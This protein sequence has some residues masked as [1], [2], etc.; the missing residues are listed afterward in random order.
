MAV[1][2]NPEL[3]QAEL[4][5]VAAKQSQAKVKTEAVQKAKKA[6]RSKVRGS[7]TPAAQAL[8]ANASIRDT[9]NASIRQLGKWKEL[10]YEQP[11]LIRDC[12][13]DFKKSV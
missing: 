12:N 8:P 5:R 11:K 10:A 3:R 9:I 13:D 4:E 2:A 1:Y 6:Q 7:A